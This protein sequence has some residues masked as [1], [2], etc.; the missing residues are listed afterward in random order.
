M[1]TDQVRLQENTYLSNAV[2]VT[3]D[4]A[5]YDASI[6]EVLADK[7]IL[8]R[9][10]KYTLEEFEE[11]DIDDI[12]RE[13]D[14]P[15]VSRVR[16]EPGQTNTPTS[17]VQKT[18]EEDT[19]PGEGQVFYDIR[20]SVFHGT[21][22]IKI[23]I[24]IEAQMSTKKSKLRYELDNRMIYYLGRMISAQKEVEFASFNYDDLKHVRSIWICMDGADDEDSISRICLQQESV[25]GKLADLHNLDKVVGVMI[26]LRANE[27]VEESKNKLIS[28]LEELLRKEAAHIKKKKLAD[29]YGL[30]MT[31]ETERR[32]SEMCNWSEAIAEREYK[33]GLKSGIERGIEKG[34]EQGIEQGESRLNELNR[35]LVKN[36][37]ID[38][39]IKATT[40]EEFRMV[41]YAEFQL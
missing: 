20:F 23:L 40:D 35:L 38:D 5:K 2:E 39:M 30:I 25:F 24:N 36:D 41:L 27:N 17:K 7:Q 26:R 6:K 29:K 11:D 14:E 33:K 16:M 15:V 18:S 12:I 19:V 10:L 4:K 1:A 13:L 3:Y 31:R 22:K 37:R 34:I 21:Q 9:I 28:M 32:V 8:A